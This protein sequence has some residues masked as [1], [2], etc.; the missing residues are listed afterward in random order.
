[1]IAKFFSSV[2]N[3]R[4][5]ATEYDAGD[6]SFYGYVSIFGRSYEEWGRFSL[7]EL[8]SYKGPFGRGIERDKGFVEKRASE[9]ILLF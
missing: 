9:A 4:W 3:S 1:V 8:E 6:K 7:E 2:G 5:Y